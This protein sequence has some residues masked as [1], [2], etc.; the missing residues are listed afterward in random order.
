RRQQRARQQ[1]RL[2]VVGVSQRSQRNQE[3]GGDGP[4]A[5]HHQARA[6]GRPVRHQLL[7]VDGRHG[8]GGEQEEAGRHQQRRLQRAVGQQ[9][10]HQRRR[11]QDGGQGHHGLSPPTIGQ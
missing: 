5:A 9:E 3:K 7:G 6:H 10:S 11:S 1:G 2:D 4:H 8:K